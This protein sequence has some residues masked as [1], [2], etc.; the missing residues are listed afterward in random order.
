MKILVKFPSRSRPDRFFRSLDS[1]YQLCYNPADMYVL[2]AADTDDAS[3]MNSFVYTKV[4]NEYKN[5]KIAYGKSDSKIHAINRNV[6]E[7]AEFWTEA[8][9]W[10]IIVVM[11]DDMMFLMPNWDEIIRM[12]M[13]AN[14]PDGDGYLHFQEKDTKRLLN[15]M[16]I[17]DR[18]YYERFGFIYHPSYLS[19]WCDNEKTELAKRLRRYKYIDMEIFVHEN[20]VYGY[21]PRDEMFDRQQADWGADEANFYKRKALNFEIEKWGLK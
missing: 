21:Q 12:E 1:L 9:D 5:I 10:D 8:A 11:S 13:K 18:T 6:N 19:L 14:F 20:P 17:M 16:E 15:V 2:V 3:M 7:L 4:V